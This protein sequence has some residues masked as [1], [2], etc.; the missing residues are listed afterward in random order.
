MSKF[1]ANQQRKNIWK[2]NRYTAMEYY[3][4]NTYQFTSNYFSKSTLS[5][6]VT[7]NVNV[8]CLKIKI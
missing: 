8:I 7:G 6:V 2:K 3:K 1:D 5:K 4:G